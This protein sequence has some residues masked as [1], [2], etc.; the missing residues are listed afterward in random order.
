MLTWLNDPRGQPYMDTHI[1]QHVV[2]AASHMY[3]RVCLLHTGR[4][5]RQT[6][7]DSMDVSPLRK[8]SRRRATAAQPWQIEALRERG[9]PLSNSISP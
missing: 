6:L 7:D 8:S 5:L 4:C 1:E 9:A 2:H 3:V